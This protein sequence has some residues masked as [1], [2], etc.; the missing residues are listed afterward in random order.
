MPVEFFVDSAIYYNASHWDFKCIDCHSVE[1]EVFPHDGELRMEEKYTCLDCHEEDKDF[2]EYRFEEVVENYELSIHS[3]KHYDDFSCWSCHDAHGYKVKFRKTSD[4]L[5]VIKYDNA[6]CLNCHS[7]K[8]NYQLLKDTVMPDI[9]AAHEWLTNRELH[10]KKVRCIE[11]HAEKHNSILI[12]HNILPAAESVKACV[13]CHSENS[14][15]LSTL[16]KFPAAENRSKGG[17]INNKILAESYVIGATKSKVLNVVSIAII[18]ITFLGIIIHGFLRLK[19]KSHNK[20]GHT[21]KT[22]LYPVWVRTWHLI[23]ALLFLVLLFTGISMQY[24]NPDYFIIR[25]DLAVTWHNVAG[26][27]LAINY[28]FFI[29]GN[30]ISGNSKFYWFKLR[31]CLKI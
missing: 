7:N 30:I 26:V 24:S 4:L 8:D 12:P 25:F 20:A 18:L 9:T 29:A 28:V 1:Y 15:L 16:Y 10:F 21:S 11:C 13:D 2:P 5:G 23:N 27:L 22:Y 6:I 19:I 31:D 3:R 14:I 17:F